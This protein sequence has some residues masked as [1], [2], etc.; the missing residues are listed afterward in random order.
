LQ[1]FLE[2]FEE[3]AKRCRLT[4]R[5][6]AKVV[7]K[8]VDRETR[9]FWTRLEGYGDDYARLKKKIMGAYSKNFLED[10]LTMAEL[11]KLVKKSAKGT[12]EDEEDL[13]TYYRKFRDIAADLVEEEIVN[14]RQHDKYFWKGLPCELCYAI[15][16]HLEARDPDFEC[17][18]VPKVEMAM[19][20][21]YFVLR[22]AAARRRWGGMS[23]KGK[24]GWREK[25]SD[26]ESSEDEKSEDEVIGVET[27]SESDSEEDE[28]KMKRS[29]KKEEEEAR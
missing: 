19:K 14:K 2:E 10:E 4:T 12:I 17:N 23:K 26:E 22:K 21:G 24:K 11:I 1:E 13:G 28:R 16:D 18:Q 29:G 27:E 20:A 8:Y 15:C 25:S 5:E 9:K 3:L 6:K 7:V